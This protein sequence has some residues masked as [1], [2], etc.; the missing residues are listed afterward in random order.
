MGNSLYVDLTSGEFEIERVE[1]EVALA[2]VDKASAIGRGGLGAGTGYHGERGQLYTSTVHIQEFR[3]AFSPEK[4]TID[5]V[6]EVYRSFKVKWSG[7]PS[8]FTPDKEHI[9]MEEAPYREVKTQPPLTFFN[10]FII[11]HL[12]DVNKATNK[13]LSFRLNDKLDRL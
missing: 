11:G 13:T 4:A 9:E 10:S 5:Y 12:F 1:L 3:L 6:P 7:C 8:C 2:L